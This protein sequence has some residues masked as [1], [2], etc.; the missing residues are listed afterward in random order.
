MKKMDNPELQNVVPEIKISL[1]RLNSN[2]T[3]DKNYEFEDSSIEDTQAKALGEEIK[4][5]RCET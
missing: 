2:W 1:Y 3:E 4:H 5:K